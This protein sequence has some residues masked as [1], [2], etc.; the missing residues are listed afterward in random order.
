MARTHDRN[1]RRERCLEGRARV[2]DETDASCTTVIEENSRISKQKYLVLFRSQPAGDQPRPSP[3]QMQ[4]MFGAYKAWMEKFK[5]P[6]FP[7]R[8]R[9]V[10]GGA[11]P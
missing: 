5:G 1:A 8:V 7:A 6:L 11:G 10:G 2:A 4:Q 9:P 3:E